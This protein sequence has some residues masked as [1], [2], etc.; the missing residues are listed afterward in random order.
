MIHAS[1][2]GVGTAPVPAELLTEAARRWRT[3]RDRGQSAQPSLHGLLAAQDCAILGPVFD[4]LMTLCEAALG[5]PLATGDSDE[6]SG[7]EELLVGL[8]DGSRRRSSAI[9]CPE[10][11]AT[12]L[13]CAICSTAIMIGLALGRRSA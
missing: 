10:G 1:H 4:S 12:A 5:R 3:A 6:R 11:T 9:V 13:D 8:L 2:D 7:D